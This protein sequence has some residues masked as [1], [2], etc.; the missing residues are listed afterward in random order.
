MS[1]P[2][3]RTSSPIIPF[4]LRTWREPLENELA[5][6]VFAIS[7]WVLTNGAT[8]GPTGG[9]CCQGHGRRPAGAT[10]GGQPVTDSWHRRGRVVASAGGN[11]RQG[12]ATAGRRRGDGGATTGR[13]LP[14]VSGGGGRKQQVSTVDHQEPLTRQRRHRGRRRVTHTHSVAVVLNFWSPSLGFEDFWGHSFVAS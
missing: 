14:T 8:E 1:S 5:A 4:L 7:R 3:R 11:R 10:A 9:R 12:R 2:S 6:I 13:R